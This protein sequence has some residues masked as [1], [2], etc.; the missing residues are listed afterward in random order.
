MQELGRDHP[1]PTAT[2][3]QV[4]D[5]VQHA[6]DV[7]GIDHVGI[8]GDYDGCDALP[9]G[10]EDVSRYP[11]LVAE[12][13]DRGWTEEDCGKLVGGNVLRVLREAQR[14]ASRLAAERAP[15]LARIET[16]DAG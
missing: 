10:L 12:L 8:G 7:A 3:R 5:H 16:L 6:R 9:A 15:S 4:A 13:L 11:L 14:I 2:L 1:R